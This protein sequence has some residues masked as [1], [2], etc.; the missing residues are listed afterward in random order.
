MT[1]IVKTVRFY[2]L[3]LYEKFEDTIEVIRSCK[4]KKDRQNNDKQK[5]KMTNNDL[6][7]TTQKTN[8]RATRNPLKIGGELRCSISIF[9][10]QDVTAELLLH[11]TP[12]FQTGLCWSI[13]SFLCSVVH[14][15]VFLLF[16]F[17]WTLYCLSPFLRIMASDYIFDISKLFLDIYFMHTFHIMS[18][19]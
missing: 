14:I 18:A 2:Y 12:G 8:G 13:F 17:F 1:V 19:N 4:S 7:N 16:F 5:E 6:Q 3:Y 9:R 11:L 10:V 15:I